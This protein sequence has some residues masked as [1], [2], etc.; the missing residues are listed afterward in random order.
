MAAWVDSPIVSFSRGGRAI[1]L[2]RSGE[3][4]ARYRAS[5]GT[6]L[7]RPGVVHIETADD[8][9]IWVG[10]ASTTCIRGEITL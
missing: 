7:G 4:P 5:Q 9:T 3:A 6:R 10:G 2:G 1:E 8:V